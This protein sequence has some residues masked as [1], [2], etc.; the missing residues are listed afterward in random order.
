MRA[1]EFGARLVSISLIGPYLLLTWQFAAAGGRPLAATI[2]AGIAGLFAAI[3]YAS[4]RNFGNVSIRRLRIY[5]VALPLLLYVTLATI[6]R[7][8]THDEEIRTR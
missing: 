2:A 5:F 1:F 7:L 8:R 4:W 6:H 3:A